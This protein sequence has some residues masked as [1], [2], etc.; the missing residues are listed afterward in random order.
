M[1]KFYNRIMLLKVS[2]ILLVCV[3][4]FNNNYCQTPVPMAS[5]VGF[6]YTEN[7]DSIANWTNNFTSG[8]G[9]NRWR[10]VG[11]ATG[12]TAAG[13]SITI[14]SAT[15]VTGTTSG[16]QKGTGNIKFLAGTANAAVAIEFLVDFSNASVDSLTMDVATIINT[17]SSIR[18][19]TFKIFYRTINSATFTELSSTA[20]DYNSTNNAVNNQH[21]SYKLPSTLND[22]SV[23]FRLYD[24]SGTG[25]GN[26]PIISLDNVNITA[27]SRSPNS[28][29][30]SKIT[31]NWT[32]ST[33]WQASSDSSHW[34]NT[35][36]YPT[37]SSKSVNIRTGD[38]VTIPA[39]VSAKRLF[40]ESG[41][42]LT[43]DNSLGNANIFLLTILDTTGTDFIIAGTYEMFGKQPSLG[44]GAIVQITNGG[45]V[46]VLA[47]N[48]P[49]TSDDFA[50]LSTVFFATG[51]VYDW[52]STS[53]FETSGLVYFPNALSNELPIFR[54]SA[55]VSGVGGASSTRFNGVFNVSANTSFSN[56]GIKYFRNGI[57]GAATLTQSTTGGIGNFVIDGD[58][59][60]IGDPAVASSIA[61]ASGG[62]LT[63]SS[64]T[65]A[66][67]LSDKTINVGSLLVNGTLKSATYRLFGTGSF[68][69]NSGGNLYMG[70][71]GGI[72]LTGSTGNVQMTGRNYD[73]NANYYYY[74]VANQVTGL[75]LPDTVKGTLQIENTGTTPNN[76]VTLTRA[77]KI[78]TALNIRSGVFKLL[79]NQDVTLL[80][81]STATANFGKIGTNGSVAYDSGRFVVE[82]YIATGVGTGH[83]GKSWQLLST[84]TTG[85]T[86]K[87]SWQENATSSSD[88]LVPGY[89]IQITSD[90]SNAT[91]V[92]FDAASPSPSMKYYNAV[93]NQWLGISNTTGLIY[94]SKGY[95]V[96]VRG[97]RSVTT[98]AQTATPTILR[99]RGYLLDSN[100]TSNITPIAVS[101]DKY[102]SI[103]NPYAS[104]IDFSKLTRSG[105]VQD[106]FYL[107]DPKL[108]SAPYSSYGYGGYQ[109]F[110]SN[111]NGTYHITPGGGGFTSNDIAG[112][113]QSGSA[114]FV[115][116]TG[117]SGTVAFSE[118]AKSEVASTLF[119]RL[120]NSNRQRLNVNMKVISSNDS[121]LLDGVMVEFG[122]DFSNQVDIDD[123]VKLVNSGENISI[124][125]QNKYLVVERR[126][127]IQQTDTIY[128]NL[129]QLKQKT[130]LLQFAPQNI[131]TNGLQGILI[132]K[133]LHTQTNIDLQT[134]TSIEFL[135]N[136]DPASS[137]NNRFYIVFQPLVSL[138]VSMISLKAT[139]IKNNTVAVCWKVANET[140][141]VQY[142][143]E[144]CLDG[145]HFYQIGEVL[146]SNNINDYSFT[147]VAPCIGVNYYRIRTTNT[148]STSETYSNVASVL[149]P[150]EE[151]SFT[152]Y[153]NPIK[154]KVVHITSKQSF[155]K[156]LNID[157][158]DMTG[159][160]IQ[161][162]E[163]RSLSFSNEI[164]FKL[165]SGIASGVY[166]LKIV[167][168]TGKFATLI[169]VD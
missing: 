102:E 62:S 99:T 105:G 9:A 150:I 133:Y 11:T 12:T 56:A 142:V 40:V 16:I 119:N 120:G 80:S 75:G 124:F 66:Q 22:S 163:V 112:L 28:Y 26:F 24:Y 110:T 41:G 92:G 73:K 32:D 47:N 165:L 109:T 50:R 35:I 154:D 30:R 136:T 65:K 61:L 147:D 86:I 63:I 82:R 33:I 164:N 6:S 104:I 140:N 85:Q 135:V 116:A 93:N 141:T 88:N 168:D 59:A 132:D 76:N 25:T 122:T 114:F 60:I 42:I 158:I 77:V 79:Y 71:V 31:G 103:G 69:L 96:F 152:V 90:V 15:F 84:S 87:A 91:S 137:A 7:F 39:D 49:G 52:S 121:I 117:T 143:V 1:F 118:N 106:V 125:S 68:Y 126:A 134:N 57:T 129:S 20:T 89:G 51:A 95:M 81:D 139:Y 37:S 149:I 45:V 162:Q 151:K 148:S 94:N 78:G 44:S 159:K 161:S 169:K 130:Y 97:N 3:I 166:Q 53:Q 4:S 18:T 67:L 113:I 98:A 38:T 157:I 111:G 2:I 74:G 115:H 54:T 46:K 153:P 8:Y 34:C 155:G 48:S 100:A 23:V 160:I 14:S 64:N 43:Y 19:S 21:L 5:Q 55:L 58:T 70:S 108:T 36:V 10:S 144:K 29:F 83:H 127:E 156:S 145:I 107:W 72:S 101:A 123:A 17:A 167:G 13:T 138:P 128:L 27:I 146:L 131:N